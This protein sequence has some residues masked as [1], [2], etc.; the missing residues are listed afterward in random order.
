MV[1]GLIFQPQCPARMQ[2]I[3]F[4]EKITY[5]C[6]HVWVKYHGHNIQI[7]SAESAPFSATSPVLKRQLYQRLGQ[8]T[9]AYLERYCLLMFWDSTRLL[10]VISL[11]QYLKQVDDLDIEKL[12]KDVLFSEYIPGTNFNIQNAVSFFL[13]KACSHWL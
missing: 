12:K 9:L 7:S 2:L 11:S 6:R 3:V 13:K 4:I 1:E 10:V 5:S 8:S